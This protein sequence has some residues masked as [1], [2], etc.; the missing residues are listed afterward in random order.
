MRSPH[1]SRSLTRS[2]GIVNV[3]FLGRTAIDSSMVS[4]LTHTEGLLSSV[5]S[6]VQEKDV[7]DEIGDEPARTR[8]PH[9]LSTSND[10]SGLAGPT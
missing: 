4:P 10:R 5:T 3:Y 6:V 8:Q 1:A 9:S 7:E 2:E